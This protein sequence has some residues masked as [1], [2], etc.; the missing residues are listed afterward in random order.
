MVTNLSANEVLQE[1]TERDLTN[2]VLSDFGN[3]S[4]TARLTLSNLSAG[5]FTTAT[6]GASTSTFSS[7]VWSVN[8][9]LAAVNALLAAVSFKPAS[10]FYGT[11]TIETYVSNGVDPAQTGTKLVTIVPVNDAPTASLLT[12]GELYIEDTPRN[13]KNIVVS[14]VDSANV[15]VTLTLSN[16]AAGTL[17]TAVS[18]AV[19]STFSAGVWTASGARANVNELLASVTFHPAA[20]FNSNFMLA[21]SIS[22][23]IAS[24]ING[25]KL[26]SGIAV[27]DAPTGTNLST[28]ESYTQGVPL[29]LA[30]IVINDVDSTAVVATLTLSNIAA[31]ALSTATSGTVTSTFLA[32]VWSAVGPV[33]NVNAL[34]AGVSFTS[35]AGFDD[36]LSIATMISDGISAPT[37]GTKQLTGIAVAS[38]PTATNLSAPETYSEDTPRNL[39]DIVVSDSDSATV[40]ATLTLSNLSAGTLSTGSSGSVTST[41]SSGEWRASGALANVNA[42]L[43]AVAFNPAPNF[44]GG[45]SIAS[46]VSDGVTPAI[47]GSKTFIGTAVN[48]APVLSGMGGTVQATAGGSAVAIDTSITLS[49][50]D[51]TTMA[52]V[53][54]AISGGFAAG[55]R[56]NFT[57]QNGI[58]GNFVGSTGVLNLSG[59]ATIANYLTALQSITF[60]T[61][62]TVA[63]NRTIAFQ[64][65]DGS[66]TS[67]SITAATVTVAVAVDS[68][69]ALASIINLANLNGAQGLKLNGIRGSSSPGFGD[70]LGYTIAGTGDVNRDGYADLIVGSRDGERLTESPAVNKG[71][72]FVVFGGS[73]AHLATLANGTAGFDLNLLNG[74]QGIALT[75]AASNGRFSNNV[76]GGGDHNGDGIADILTSEQNFA[77]GNSNGYVIYGDST[78]NGINGNGLGGLN[79]L[80]VTQ[81]IGSN[82]SGAND[83]N[84]DGVDDGLQLGGLLAPLQGT[85]IANGGDLDNDGI[86]D[87]VVGN[88]E[89]DTTR[90]TDSGEAFV[91]F[92]ASSATLDGLNALGTANGTNVLSFFGQ[93]ASDF[94]GFGVSGL[95]DIDHDGFDDFALG[96]TGLAQDGKVYVVFGDTRS[97]LASL[98]SAVNTSGFNATLNGANGFRLVTP[99]FAPFGNLQTGAQ[100]S[101]IGDFNGDMIDDFAVSSAGISIGFVIFG[102]AGGFTSTIDLTAVM[103]TRV[104]GFA[105]AA[106]LSDIAGAG[107]VN[108]DGLADVIVGSLGSNEAY[109][110][111]GTSN[112][113][114]LVRNVAAYSTTMVDLTDGASFN[115]SGLTLQSGGY[116]NGKG[117]LLDG[118][119]SSSAGAA[120]DGI[121]D[122]N[123][124]GFDDI[125][126]G[127]FNATTA[128]SIGN[129]AGQAYVV[130]G[131]DY[132]AAGAG[133]ASQTATAGSQVLRGGA[134]V[135]A[136]SSGGFSGVG[137]TAG[138][139][140][141][142]IRVNGTEFGVNGGGG[143][144]ILT[145]DANGISLNF[146]ALTNK[147]LYA[148]IEQ[149]QLDGFGANTVQLDLRDVLE[150]SGSMNELLV[151]GDNGTDT[152]QSSGQGWLAN[153]TTSRSVLIDDTG[154]TSSL[155][156]NVYSHAASHANLLI[157]QGLNQSIIS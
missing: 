126:V 80:L 22:D 29:N 129:P 73:A 61:T 99:P 19:T 75:G 109:V 148:N 154:L 120:V 21:A 110:L 68:G 70:F 51:N 27:N 81:L 134:G 36:N 91:V 108:G 111:Y 65:S 93:G 13:L 71:R 25:S 67:A 56:L 139:G 101:A 78:T 136:L 10:N 131:A 117:L 14:D 155:T 28:A 24:A 7:G 17:S 85:S 77:G 6:A 140:N 26:F 100:L 59:T 39:T 11:V 35:A 23:G 57:S 149:I 63:G 92:G 132:G 135:N 82:T 9:S 137:H 55:D 58:S 15:T 32:G 38:A 107:D 43:A 62:S 102:K 125:A 146:D 45:F 151:T 48:D 118:V 119:A 41:F 42:L 89:R 127:A 54:V 66:A 97:N 31:G 34:L 53:A 16:F 104:G 5:V 114:G 103:N 116:L 94:T 64:A 106:G 145:P 12:A 143:L 124:D 142:V 150:M 144:D 95:G 3:G 113:A 121:G 152:V 90:G 141:D 123:G 79:N 96:A 49:D 37:L 98:A 84:S 69:G 1:D 47:T 112:I 138:A 130:Y 72:A 88:A 44:N 8:G 133:L 74:T 18:G 153:G 128:T 122:F 4:F 50:V 52:S 105:I 30:N 2:I 33:A 60:Q 83:V 86:D 46:M 156:F 20:N 115:G 87:I 157:E 147:N 40:T 76:D